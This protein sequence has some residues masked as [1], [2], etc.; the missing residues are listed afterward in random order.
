MDFRPG[1]FFVRDTPPAPAWPEV[2]SRFDR[3]LAPVVEQLGASAGV[4]EPARETIVTT[5]D[6]A[7]SQTYALTV[8]T[9]AGLVNDEQH[10]PDDLTIGNLVV[11]GAG[12]DA[13]DAGAR[14]YIPPSGTPIASSFVEPEPPQPTGVDTSPQAPDSQQ[15]D[16]P[17]A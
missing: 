15:V 17:G 14:P 9:A 8:G 12:A 11:A 4:L 3:T 13:A 2:S 10:K 1:P 16:T 7:M 6:G 5:D